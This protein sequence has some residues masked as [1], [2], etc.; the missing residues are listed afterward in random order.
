MGLRPLQIFYFFQCEDRLQTSESDVCRR[1]MLTYKDGPSTE[2]VKD[3]TNLLDIPYSD[4]N[5]IERLSNKLA[6]P[7]FTS[8]LQQIVSLKTK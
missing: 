3:D 2:R 4:L 7:A 6:L 5:S 1:Q 8:R